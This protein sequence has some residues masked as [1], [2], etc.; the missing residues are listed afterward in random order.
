MSKFKNEFKSFMEDMEKNIKNKEDL[1]YVKGRTSEFLNV[2]LD[3]MEGIVNYEEEK[4]SLL[5]EEQKQ[6]NEKMQKMQQVLDNIEQDIYSDEGFDFEIVCP[7]C[8]YEFVI[9]VDDNKTEIKCPKCDSIMKC[10]GSGGKKKK[11]MYYNCEHCKIYYR[12]DKIEECLEDFILDLVEYDMAVKKYFFPILADK[13]ET[14]TEKLDK[15]IDT[16]QKQKK[17]LRKHI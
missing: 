13:K 3:Q 10:K 16:L 15:E 6:I 5:E 11:Y 14:N 17:E 12:E 1:E 7:Y 8:D 2:I 9:D 4:I